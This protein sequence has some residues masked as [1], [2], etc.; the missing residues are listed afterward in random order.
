[1]M[2]D[3]EVKSAEVEVSGG[4][5]PVWLV[6]I[7]AL[8]IA[9]WLGV[10][11]WQQTG[12]SIDILFNSASGIVEGKTEIRYKDVKVGAVKQI[13]LS[14]DLGTVSVTAELDPAIEPH[15]SDNSR[16]WVVRPR[17]SLSGVSGL[18]T[19]FSG[20]YI[21]IDP[22]AAGT[23]QDQFIGLDESPSVKSTDSG[24]PFK[25]HAEQLGSLDIGSPVYYR[26]IRVGEVT[27]YTL[28]PE[29]DRVD[30]TIF[31][32]TPY[33][34]LV[35]RQSRFWNVS[36]AGLELDV[37]G[38][39]ARI[40][41]VAALLQGGIAFDSPATLDNPG[42][43]EPKQ[44]FFLFGDKQAASEE[45][46][47]LE[48]HFLLEFKGS[49]RGLKV[50]APVEYRGIK[51]GELVEIRLGLPDHGGESITALISLQPQ[52]LE[53]DHMPTKEEMFA[54]MASMVDSGL[55]AQL[56]TG[57]LLTGALY[58]DLIKA[59]ESKGAFDS[60][61]PYPRIPTLDTPFE[62]LERQL[63]SVMDKLQKFP[64]NQVAE[65]LQAS[66][67]SMRVMLES[68]AAPAFVGKVDATVT[69]LQGSSAQLSDT[70]SAVTKAV[71]QLEKTLLTV[72]EGVSPDS[73]LYYELLKMMDEI[74][75]ASVSFKGLTEELE[76]NPN[77]LIFG[78]G[79][80]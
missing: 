12:P 30:I 77:A 43:A 41:S 34:H 64:L 14:E 42:P 8:G 55:R 19:L 15:L 61:G 24:S 62:Q 46:Y 22:G 47:T 21:A 27:G 20:V 60:E 35:Q 53:K 63:G 69:N 76:R 23:Y 2:T 38:V 7:I 68:L 70:L 16:F 48:Y 4:L 58:I 31:V 73:E 36:G 11:A 37:E 40:E 33:D 49:V 59:P 65:D 32:D 72:D 6:P 17:I 74:T 5:S 79:S 54:R 18:S 13:S 71:T 56:K 28:A 44:D 26:Q 10:R 66:L 52:R 45:A 25:L 39:R 51:V 1:M 9:V 80:K 29:G 50:G 3:T 78:K 75:K 67:G 57:N